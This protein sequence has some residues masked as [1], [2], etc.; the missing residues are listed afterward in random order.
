MSWCSAPKLRPN[1]WLLVFD[2]ESTC[3]TSVPWYEKEIIECRILVVS[4]ETRKRISE[5]HSYVRAG[6]FSDTL[7]P[8]CVQLTGVTQDQLN[9]APTFVNFFKS[10]DAF[11]EPFK[12]EGILVTVDDWDLFTMLPAQCLRYNYELPTFYRRYLN[13]RTIMGEVFGKRPEDVTAMFHQLGMPLACYMSSGLEYGRHI[14]AIVEK[15]LAK[16]YIFETNSQNKK[17]LNGSSKDDY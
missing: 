3:G 12:Q 9:S 14:A 17:R 8:M 5:F 2:L 4:V 15:I 10:M 7:N 13:L 11:C 16:G 6:T 1:K